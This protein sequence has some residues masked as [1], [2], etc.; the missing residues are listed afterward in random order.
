M[1]ND[2]PFDPN[3]E[4]MPDLYTVLQVTRTATDAELRTAYRKLALL[5]H[6]DKHSHLDASSDEAKAKTKQF[7]QIGF[8][9]SILK[10][11][12]RRKIY[13]QTGSLA[14][15]I[16]EEGKDW[17]AY[18]RQLWTG[19]V[20]A[21]TIAQFAKVYKRSEEER[22]DIL[23]AYRLH[24][25]DIGLIMTEVMLAEVEDEPRF[26]DII[27]AA[28]SAEEVKRTRA[29]TKSK[30]LATKRRADAEDEA[31]EAEALRKELGLD[32]QL[33]KAK[34]NSKANS[35][36]KGGSKRNR[37]GASD[38]DEGDEGAIKA[39]IRQRTNSRM[40]SVIANIEEKYAK[41]S[42]SK[43]GKGGSKKQ[44]PKF[45]E[46]SEEEFQALQ[47]KMFAKK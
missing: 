19:V 27:E 22:G 6:P 26:V 3:S 40:S 37:S 1:S 35:K 9:Y 2:T 31:V 11:T 38:D 8:A 10:D 4:D 32:D 39:L 14:V 7:Q 41:K 5:T 15:P 12:Q 29:Y 33:R 47:A 23:A 13:D 34:A 20:D 16:L 43:K 30:K 24:E 36:A 42:A 28:I 44:A 18:F 21:Q 25:G 45:S 17:D 46:P